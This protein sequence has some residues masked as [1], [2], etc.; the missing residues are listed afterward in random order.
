[1]VTAHA[2]LNRKAEK[3]ERNQNDVSKINTLIAKNKN[4]HSRTKSLS[5]SYD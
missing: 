5:N 1:M 4:K 3:L 2:S